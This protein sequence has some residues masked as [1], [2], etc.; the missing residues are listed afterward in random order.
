MGTISRTE[1][2]SRL[3]DVEDSF[4]ERYLKVRI[5]IFLAQILLN[6]PI[7]KRRL[8]IFSFVAWL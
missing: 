1:E 2:V 5:R 8:N 6:E 4:E 3:N 7:Y